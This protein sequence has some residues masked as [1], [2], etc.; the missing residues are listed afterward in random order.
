MKK[1][2]IRSR[3][4]TLLEN[5]MED[6]KSEMKEDMMSPEDIAAMTFMGMDDDAVQFEARGRISS[7]F[8]INDEQAVLLDPSFEAA[9]P[10]ERRTKIADFINRVNEII[11]AKKRFAPGQKRPTKAFSKDDLTRLLALF[12]DEEGFTSKDI[13]S[14]VESYKNVQQANAFLKALEMKGY[15]KLTNFDEETGKF[16]DPKKKSAL[17]PEDEFDADLK[18]LAGLG[19]DI[20]LSDPLMEG[21]QPSKLKEIEAKGRMAALEAKLEAINEMIE[22]I[23]SSLT[24]L[25]EDDTMAEMMDKKKMKEMRKEVKLL[26]RMKAK[27]EKEK[28]KMEG[29]G[30]KSYKSKE[31]MDEDTV[32]ESINENQMH[33]ELLKLVMRYVKDPDEAADQAEYII[34]SNLD[35]V[36]DMVQA[37]LERDP[38]YKNWA[39]RMN[40]AQDFEKGLGNLNES[41]SRMQKLAGLIKG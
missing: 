19:G 13:V 40:A 35:M 7:I 14:A 24:R 30:M 38:D 29:K 22:N 4:R 39:K 21:K 9:S 31:V 27:V 3:V 10:E 12:T 32:D 34:T 28:T 16:F 26:E 41:K 17:A 2:E 15:I 33:D 23:T 25:E 6:E 36:D 37:N 8:A 1:S 18:D 5:Y 11:M 20:D